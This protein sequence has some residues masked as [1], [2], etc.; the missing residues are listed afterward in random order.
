MADSKKIVIGL[1][2]AAV[3]TTAI[4]LATRAKAAPPPGGWCCPY[5]D[6]LCFDTYEELVLH[7]QTAHPG[8]RIPLP[9]EWE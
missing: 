8:E 5:G 6:G 7:I 9:I 2:L 4:I 1:G 3:A